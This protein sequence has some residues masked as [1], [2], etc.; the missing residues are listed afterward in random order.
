MIRPSGVI[1]R[2]SGLENVSVR[3]E[4]LDML[5]RHAIHRRRR[6]LSSISLRWKHPIARRWLR[7]EQVAHEIVP[8]SLDRIRRTL[9]A[10]IGD[11]Q[12]VEVLPCLL[13]RVDEPQR[14]R[15]LR[16]RIGSPACRPAPDARRAR[17]AADE[18]QVKPS[19]SRSGLRFTAS[20]ALLDSG[21]PVT[22][23]IRSRS[24]SCW[25]RT[26]SRDLW[27]CG[28]CPA[29]VQR[30]SGYCAVPLLSRQFSDGVRFVLTVRS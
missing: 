25:M 21:S 30:V 23:P 26:F 3:N 4:V 17:C 18:L 14:L 2:G 10:R 22:I 9:M 1:G 5:K 8:P 13:E 16:P 19:T 12:H 29:D 24:S 28:T 27:R 7:P 15:R 6:R 20:P 11:D